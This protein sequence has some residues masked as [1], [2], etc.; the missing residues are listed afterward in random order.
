MLLIASL[1]ESIKMR[2]KKLV[3]KVANPRR[4]YNIVSL[5]SHFDSFF[6]RSQSMKYPIKSNKFITRDYRKHSNITI[7]IMYNYPLHKFELNT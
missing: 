4:K 2:K 6:V 7:R 3:E 1:K 5:L